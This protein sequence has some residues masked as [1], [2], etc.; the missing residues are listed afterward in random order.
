MRQVNAKDFKTHFD[1]FVDL[2]RDEPIEVL[3]GRKSLGVFLC[4]VEYA[5]FRRLEHMYWA[6]CARAVDVVE[7]TLGHEDA[8]EFLAKGIKC[9]E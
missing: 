8:V 4:P 9:P 2:V 6:A 3:R 5:H 7:E 1:D